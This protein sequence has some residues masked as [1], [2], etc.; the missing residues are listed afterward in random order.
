M[1]ITKIVL[2]EALE[3]MIEYNK[4]GYNCYFDNG[5]LVINLER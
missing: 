4:K 1:R 2:N 5:V 3:M